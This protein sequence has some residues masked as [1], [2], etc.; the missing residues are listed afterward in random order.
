MTVSLQSSSGAT[1]WK[2]MA[3]RASRYPRPTLRCRSNLA[4]RPSSK[5]ASRA[6]LKAKN[7]WVEMVVG[8]GCHSPHS[9]LNLSQVRRLV[10]HAWTSPGSTPSRIELRMATG[11]IPGR[12]PRH[13]WEP[14]KQASILQSSHGTS[15]P[16]REETAST[17]KREPYSC[18][19]AP[20]SLMGFTIPV[21]VSEC[22]AKRALT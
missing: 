21:D 8:W 17:T 1:V 10:Y 11:A 12:A 16:P 20:S 14:A 18:A 15:M 9:S 2:S 5:T 4:S 6:A 3:P 7:T 13:F 19:S 22:T